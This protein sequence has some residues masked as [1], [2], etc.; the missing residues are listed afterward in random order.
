MSIELSR[1]TFLKLV[2]LSLVL[3]AVILIVAVGESFALRWARFSAEFDA[4]LARE[5]VGIDAYDDNAVIAAGTILV[6]L[7][8][9]NVASLIGLLRFRRWARTG[10]VASTLLLLALGLPFPGAATTFT[11]PWMAALTFVDSALIGAVVMMAY[12]A[13]HGHRWFAAA[14]AQS[15]GD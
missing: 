11:T 9:W 8:A 1:T 3:L 15:E 6:A 2:R 4:L 14:T 7:L 5:F 12:S 13:D 10:L